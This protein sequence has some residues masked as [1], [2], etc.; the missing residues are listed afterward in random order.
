[1]KKSHYQIALGGANRFYD[2]KNTLE[3]HSAGI[4]SPHMY[5]LINNGI[6]QQDLKHN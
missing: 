1:M 5:L 4:K 6:A 3:N 2:P